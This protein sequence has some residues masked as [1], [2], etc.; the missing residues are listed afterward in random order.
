MKR[1]SDF[2]PRFSL[3][4]RQTERKTKGPDG[5]QEKR[6]DFDLELN[7]NYGQML[8]DNFKQDKNSN[9]KPVVTGQLRKIFGFLLSVF[10]LLR[11]AGVE[12]SLVFP[13]YVQ[14]DENKPVSSKATTISDEDI[15]QLR[16]VFKDFLLTE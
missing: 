14:A 10:I 5:K 2:K 6:R 3:R 4:L 7:E 1:T 11:I 8:E 16:E 15:A 12:I 13:G 9:E